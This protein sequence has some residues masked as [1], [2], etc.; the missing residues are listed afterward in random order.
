MFRTFF[1][2]LT[3]AAVLVAFAA[4]AAHADEPPAIDV[5]SAQLWD[6]ITTER[7]V[8]KGVIIHQI[9]GQ[10]YTIA[11]PGGSRITVP[12]SDVQSISKEANPGYEKAQIAAVVPGPAPVAVAT[13][14]EAAGPELPPPF[15][16]AGLRLS[17]TPMLVVPTGDLEDGITTSFGVTARAGYEVMFG[18][19]GVTP[20]VRGEYIRLRPED[21]RFGFNFVHAGAELRGAVHLG[22]AIPYFGLGVGADISHVSADRLDSETSV[23]PGITLSFGVDAAVH[24]G[25]GLGLGMTFHP[26]LTEVID[27]TDVNVGYFAIGLTVQTL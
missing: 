4:T 14:S 20:A 5:E 27:D 23:G 1:L 9:P 18:R 26:G 22:R 11:L 17:A 25:F 16:Q 2:F 6:V 13:V 15:A 3:S 24:D 10:E 7:S 21:D 19:F 8:L 12:H